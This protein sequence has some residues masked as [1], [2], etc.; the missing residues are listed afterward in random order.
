MGGGGDKKEQKK[1][2]KQMYISN[3]RGAKEKKL[4]TF[5]AQIFKIKN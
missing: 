5:W 3:A 2:K 1:K 4:R